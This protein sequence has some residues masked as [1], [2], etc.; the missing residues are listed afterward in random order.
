MRFEIKKL[1][2]SNYKEQHCQYILE[3]LMIVDLTYNYHNVEILKM[4]KSRWVWDNVVPYMAECLYRDCNQLRVR[5]LPERCNRDMVIISKYHVFLLMAQ[6]FLGLLPRQISTYDLPISFGEI[7]TVGE[8]D[9]VTVINNK[10]SKL[11]CILHYFSS[12]LREKE[13]KIKN[14]VEFISFQRFRI[15]LKLEALYPQS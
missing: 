15:S 14:C 11:R 6:M 7:M 4:I 8:N 13:E 5:L 9:S 2:K 1:I 10:Q 12:I 3:R